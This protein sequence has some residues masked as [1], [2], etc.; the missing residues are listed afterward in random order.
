MTGRSRL[1]QGRKAPFRRVSCRAKKVGPTNRIG[2]QRF[3]IVAISL[4][5]VRDCVSLN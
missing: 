1:L 2:G 5:C 4:H 3:S